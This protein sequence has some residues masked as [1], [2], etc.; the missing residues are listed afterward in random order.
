MT[1]TGFFREILRYFNTVSVK[2]I[3]NVSGVNFDLLLYIELTISFMI[4]RKRTSKGY[5]LQPSASA[6]NLYLDH[7]YSGYHKNLNQ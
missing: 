3:I 1:S 4:G 2:E 5:Q 6:D 7:D